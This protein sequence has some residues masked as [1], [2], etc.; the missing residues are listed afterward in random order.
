MCC[1]VRAYLCIIRTWRREKNVEDHRGSCLYMCIIYKGDS[2]VISSA[3]YVISLYFS[4]YIVTCCRHCNRMVSP[5]L[6][7][8]FKFDPSPPLSRN[9]AVTTH[10]REFN[11][12]THTYECMCKRARAYHSLRSR[13]LRNESS[14]GRNQLHVHSYVPAHSHWYRHSMSIIFYFILTHRCL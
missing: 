1:V 13:D 8:K 2:D 6:A 9:T 4:I 14:H 3:H 5:P 11:S 12:H 7:I 10:V